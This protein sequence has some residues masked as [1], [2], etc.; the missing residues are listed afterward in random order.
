MRIKISELKTAAQ[1]IIDE[2]RKEAELQVKGTRTAFKHASLPSS[3]LMERLEIPL[4][5]IK[6][7]PQG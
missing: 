3:G 1:L 5:T 4:E 6:W 7:N 2:T